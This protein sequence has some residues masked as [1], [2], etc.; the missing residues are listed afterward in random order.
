[1]TKT[2]EKLQLLAELEG[3][4]NITEMLKAAVFDSVAPSICM[5]ANCDYTAEMEP[6]QRE[7]YCELCETNSVKSCFILAGVI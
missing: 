7:G 4:D 1:M 6:D 3:F 2:Q 5:N